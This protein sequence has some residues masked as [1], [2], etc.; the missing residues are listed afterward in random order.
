[1]ADRESSRAWLDAAIR[2]LSDPDR[3]VACPACDGSLRGELV[4]HDVGAA[5]VLRRFVICPACRRYEE[6]LDRSGTVPSFT[7]EGAFDIIWPSFSRPH[8]PK[9]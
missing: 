7:F 1:M 8:P 5:N 2:K 6:L 9:K 3:V 4:L